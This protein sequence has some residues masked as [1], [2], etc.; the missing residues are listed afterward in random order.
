MNNRLWALPFCAFF[1]VALHAQFDTGQIAGY[2]RDPSQALVTGAA[3]TV[4]NEGNGF[5]SQTVTN[6]NGYY[7]V[8]NLAVGTYSVTAESAGFK[9][10]VQSGIV[11]DSAAK[12][13]IDLTLVVGAV[14]DTVEVKANAVQIQTES[15]Q[16]GRVVDTKQIQDLM[17]NGRNPIYLA[18][19]KPG[20]AGGAIGTFDPDSVSNGGFNINGGRADEYVVTIDGAVATR[21]RS[22]GSMLGAQ[23]ID[24]VQEV[25]ILTANYNAE[26][27]RSS[28]GQIR[29]VTK[30]GTLNFHGD[31]VENFRNSALDANDWTRNHS[32]LASQNTGPA[33]FRFNQYGFDISGPAFIPKKTRRE[34]TKLFFLWAEEWIKRREGNTATGTV[35]SAAMRTGDM[36]E[37]LNP[38]NSYFKKVIAITDPTTGK[39]YPGNIIPP[40][41]ISH[42]GQAL[43]N[44]YPLPTPGFLQGT[45][46]Y[47]VTYPH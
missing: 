26:Y 4:T 32:P 34:N 20:V 47:I 35:P 14:S 2:V 17:T 38:A 10:T 6:Q 39:P 16:V 9:K 19:L 1:S 27:G 41:Q 8:P 3:V 22:S 5:R 11:L 28:G 15:A 7:V 13:N 43:L 23:D 37:L 21:T 40:G 29:F 42:N 31:L 18:L 25:Q 12:L 45:S 30:S 36:S 33:P 44:V 46:N 24:T